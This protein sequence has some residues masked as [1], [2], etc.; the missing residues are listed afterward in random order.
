MQRKSPLRHTERL[1]RLDDGRMVKIVKI[2]FKTGPD[3]EW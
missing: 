2:E 1:Y 3:A